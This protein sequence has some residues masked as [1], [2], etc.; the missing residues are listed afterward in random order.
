MRVTRYFLQDASTEVVERIR[1]E[2]VSWGQD[3]KIT[4]LG[5]FLAGTDLVYVRPTGVYVVLHY[6]SSEEALQSLRTLGPRTRASIGYLILSDDRP[7][8]PVY[9][10]VQE[11]VYHPWP[12]P[13]SGLRG[14]ATAISMDDQVGIRIEAAGTDV[15]AVVEHYLRV[16]G[17]TVPRS[18]HWTDDWIGPL[19]ESLRWQL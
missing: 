12:V 4:G 18:G 3:R 8:T 11:G 14:R 17:G 16:R 13:A 7:I 15:D 6:A 5:S 1:A 2:T 9:Q 10:G 19:P